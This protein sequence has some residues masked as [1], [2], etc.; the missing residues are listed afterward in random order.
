[1]G[2]EYRPEPDAAVPIYYPTPIEP[3]ADRSSTVPSVGLSAAEESEAACDGVFES[4][5]GR[6]AGIEGAELPLAPTAELPLAPNAELP[7]APNAE[8]PLAPTAELPLAPTAELPL[9]PTAELPLAPNAELPLA[10]QTR[11]QATQT[12]ADDNTI[13]SWLRRQV[14]EEEEAKVREELDFLRSQYE[15]ITSTNCR[16]GVCHPVHRHIIKTVRENGKEITVVNIDVNCAECPSP[17]VPHL[18]R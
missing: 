16:H 18:R 17:N 3:R 8:L 1:M 11:E 2:E 6:E 14:R 13:P 4:A 15:A 7:L 9:V 10:V 5:A 12:R